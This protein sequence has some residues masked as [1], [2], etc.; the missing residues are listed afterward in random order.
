MTP[1]LIV[2]VGAGLGGML[3]HGVNSL[4]ASWA[5]LSFPWGTLAV[6][7]LGS[8][9]MGVVAGLFASRLDA[10]AG[11]RLFLATGILGGFTTF[12]SFSLDSVVLWERGEAVAAVGYGIASVA[13]SIAALCAGLWL[14]RATTAG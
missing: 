12:S 4:A 14:V 2:F 13:L 9:A 7:L 8:F 10:G 11:W 1:Y 6:N 5:G 3:R